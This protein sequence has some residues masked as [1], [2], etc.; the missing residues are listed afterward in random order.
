MVGFGVITKIF[1]EFA[2][3]N[4]YY[5]KIWKKKFVYKFPSKPRS[6]KLLNF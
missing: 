4:I 5:S 3:V 6:L 1:L 2:T